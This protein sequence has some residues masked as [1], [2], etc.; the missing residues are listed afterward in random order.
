MNTGENQEGLKKILD[1][2]RLGSL[3]LLGIH[4]YL[5]AYVQLN[6]WGF[7]HEWID[8][9]LAQLAKTGLLQGNNRIR[10]FSLVL[11]W[12]SL[13]GAKGRKDPDLK[14]G[15]LLLWFLLWNAAFVFAESAIRD[16][17][18]DKILYLA[19]IWIAWIGI[20]TMGGKLSRVIRDGFSPEVFN[21]LHETFPSG[22]TTP[23][24]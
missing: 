9:L 2:T 18:W 8:F 24:K 22:T 12:I 23:G 19:G 6:S 16:L 17:G 3:V 21:H 15:R 20:L 1:F 11:L 13:L 7:T 14:W 10:I 5:I 4:T